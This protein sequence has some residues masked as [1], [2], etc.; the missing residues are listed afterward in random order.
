MHCVDTRRLLVVTMV[1]FV[2]GQNASADPATT[3]GLAGTPEFATCSDD[4][5]VDPFVPPD[6][7]SDVSSTDVIEFLRKGVKNTS[8]AVPSATASFCNEVEDDEASGARLRVLTDNASE[9][10]S[11]IFQKDAER[12]IALA[13]ILSCT[14]FTAD[15]VRRLHM[16]GHSAAPTPTLVGVHELIMNDPNAALGITSVEE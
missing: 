9:Y 8:R 3:P 12:G 2:A 10:F 7:D 6:G 16:V 11:E 13:E 15:M 5:H 14:P 4:Q 1:L